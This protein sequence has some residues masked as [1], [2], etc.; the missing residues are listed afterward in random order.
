MRIVLIV[1]LIVAA[2]AGGCE[3]VQSLYPFYDLKDVLPV[4]ALEGTWMSKKEDGF[5]MKL[6][7]QKGQ[8][9][10]GGYTVAVLFHADQPDKGKPKEGT[11]RFSVHFFQAGGS[12]FADFYPLA[13]SM[14]SGSRTI[15]FE[16]KDN[17]FGTPTHT[18]YQVKMD[19]SHLQLAWLDADSVK[20]FLVKNNF[21]LAAK[22]PDFLLLTGRADELKASLLLQA[23]KEDLVDDV[24]VEFTRQE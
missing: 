5:Y 8:D 10:T 12:R 7:F 14:K 4:P 11:I 13:Y 24:G 19:E 23:E 17:P 9:K 18:V 15:E 20:K 21:K 16:A 1:V 6:R 22:G 2:L 3:P